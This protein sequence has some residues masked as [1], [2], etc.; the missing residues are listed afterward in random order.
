[1]MS[2]ET[3]RFE[4]EK[5]GKYDVVISGYGWVSF[6]YTDQIVEVCVPKNCKVYLREALI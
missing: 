3:K 4:I 5:P 6:E 1:M 2:M